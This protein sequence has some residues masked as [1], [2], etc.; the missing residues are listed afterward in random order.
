MIAQQQ[1]KPSLGLIPYLQKDKLA[2]DLQNTERAYWWWLQ[3]L[4]LNKQQIVCSY[5]LTITKSPS[6]PVIG[7]HS[8][9]ERITILSSLRIKWATICKS[10]ERKSE[11]HPS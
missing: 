1:D 11:L 10:A 6:N 8:Q 9:W 5:I 4:Q 7:S 3:L 2:N